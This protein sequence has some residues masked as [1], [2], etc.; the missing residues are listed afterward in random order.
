M[1]TKNYILF[2]YFY[3]FW[4]EVCVNEKKKFK[5]FSTNTTPNDTKERKIDKRRKNDE[6]K[7]F[8]SFV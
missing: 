8:I 1:K 3:S 4:K 7:I 2:F 6:K 5:I